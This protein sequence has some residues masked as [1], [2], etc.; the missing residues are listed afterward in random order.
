[1]PSSQK[2]GAGGQEE[3]IF[4]VINAGETTIEMIYKR[5][6]EKNIHTSK[7]FHVTIQ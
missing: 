3:F 4:N 6:W 5:P 1:M 2:M 7:K